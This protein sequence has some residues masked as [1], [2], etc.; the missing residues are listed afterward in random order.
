MEL[1]AL[2]DL[3]G[4]VF[5]NLEAHPIRKQELRLHERGYIYPTE[6]KVPGTCFLLFS[7]V[8]FDLLEEG[9]QS[10]QSMVWIDN[11]GTKSFFSVYIFQVSRYSVV[12][13]CVRLYKCHQTTHVVGTPQR[14]I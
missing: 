7:G 12:D 10:E 3:L 13:A 11:V 14:V 1:Q 5:L 2:S 6:Q 9:V 8:H 4:V